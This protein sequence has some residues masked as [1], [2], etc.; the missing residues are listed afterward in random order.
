MEP[1][2]ATLCHPPAH[3]PPTCTPPTT[4]HLP[5]HATPRHAIDLPDCDLSTHPP[6]ISSCDRQLPPDL[7]PYPQSAVHCLTNAVHAG[8]G[9]SGDRMCTLLIGLQ[10]RETLNFLCTGFGALL[11]NAYAARA[12]YLPSSQRVRRLHRRAAR[13]HIYTRCPARQA[14]ACRAYTP[15]SVLQRPPAAELRFPVSF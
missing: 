8:E 12:T 4:C 3:L 2:H 1:R 13:A 5:H 7:I 6:M 14:P 10:R 15:S 11:G 9:A